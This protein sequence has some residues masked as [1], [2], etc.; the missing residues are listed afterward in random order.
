MPTTWT[1]TETIPIHSVKAM[2]PTVFRETKYVHKFIE[3]YIKCR[4]GQCPVNSRETIAG[5][6]GIPEMHDHSEHHSVV[7]TSSK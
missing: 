5:V 2:Q 3:I 1:I 7:N 6:F 4:L